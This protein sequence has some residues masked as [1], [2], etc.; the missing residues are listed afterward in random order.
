MIKINTMNE[1]L[2]VKLKQAPYNPR[3][4]EEDQFESLKESM[5]A[6]PEF[7]KVR[8]LI[9]NTRAGR[10]FVVIAGNMRLEAAK[11][12]GWETIP[13]IFVDV[14]MDKEK[15]W[16]IK[17][18]NQFGKWDDQKLA[19]IVYAMKDMPSVHNLGFG[20]NELKNIIENQTLANLGKEDDDEVEEPDRTKEAESKRGEIYELG[21]HRLMCGDS[22]K[23][24]DVELLLNG[25]K[26]DLIFADPPY[27]IGF[28]YNEHQDK[29]SDEDYK[30]F[31]INWY[32][33][34]TG[35][36]TIVTPGPRNIGIW[37]SIEKPTDIGTW[38][39][40]NSRSGAS[41][42]YI[43]T[44]EPILFFRKFKGKRNLDYFDYTRSI[45][46]ELTEAE[47]GAGVKDVA[48]SKPIALICD[49]LKHYSDKGNKIYDPFG[50]SGTTLLACSKMGRKC[51]MMEM[52]PH[53]CDVI[54]QRYKQLSTAE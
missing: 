36:P 3:Y 28:E 39:K 2:I 8:P 29:M 44:C 5:K 46:K 16:N 48:P 19:E 26:L 1:E 40:K 35:V 15:E 20:K 21:E 42:F 11:A 9:V 6:D 50:G 54:R 4:I 33:K 31:M 52:D 49:L 24:S 30:Q 41:V 7:L 38:Y 14:D 47:E 37:E 17:D 22:T 27:N 23:D 34:I 43:R 13:V 18:N 53:Y 51:Y 12:L 32:A 25:A 45:S 10:E